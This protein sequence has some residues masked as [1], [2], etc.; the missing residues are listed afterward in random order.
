MDLCC[1]LGLCA[2]A[3]FPSHAFISIHA[4]LWW[5]CQVELVS[6]VGR[7]WLPEDDEELDPEATRLAEFVLK[8]MGEWGRMGR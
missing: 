5:V 6:R 3:L 1:E 7:R 4:G 2:V 8:V